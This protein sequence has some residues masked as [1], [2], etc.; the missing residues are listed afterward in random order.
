MTRT[1]STAPKTPTQ[2]EWEF[3]RKLE[4]NVFLTCL[5]VPIFYTRNTVVPPMFARK[6]FSAHCGK[7]MSTGVP[8]SLKQQQLE[9][10][11]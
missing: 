4:V 2:N 10:K 3:Q 8:V 9:T 5:Y 6:P 11:F 7:T 1:S